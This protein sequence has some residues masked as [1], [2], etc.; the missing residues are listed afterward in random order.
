LISNAIKYSP[1]GGDITITCE[2]NESFVT[3]TV[4]DNGIGIPTESLSKVFDRF[5]R[6]QTKQNE[7]IGGIGLGLYITSQI[8]RKHGGSITVRSNEGHGSV[9]CFTIP[10]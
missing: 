3:V 7:N 4:T 10:R 6:M 1:D 2:E 5:F 9:F 8:I